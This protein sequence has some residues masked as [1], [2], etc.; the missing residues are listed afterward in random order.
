MVFN[1]DFETHDILQRF[2][3]PIVFN[4]GLERLFLRFKKTQGNTFLN[5]G[6]A[7]ETATIDK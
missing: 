7:G 1:G 5:D 4:R 2:L 3:N 6:L